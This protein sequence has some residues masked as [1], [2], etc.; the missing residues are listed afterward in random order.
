M[1]FPDSWF[2]DE[3]RDGFFVAGMMKRAWAAQLE[4]LED[5]DKV[6]KKHGILWF[7]ERCLV[8]SGTEGLFPGTTIWISV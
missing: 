4:V 5:I 6:C 3:V 8:R 2:L 7:A 1:E